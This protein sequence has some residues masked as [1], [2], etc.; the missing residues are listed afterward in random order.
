MANDVKKQNKKTGIFSPKVKKTKQREEQVSSLKYNQQAIIHNNT[1]FIIQE[2]YKTARTNIIFSVAGNHNAGCKIIG[3]TSANPGEGKTTTCINMS[4]TF[5]QTGARVLIIDGDL[6]NPSVHQYL[7]VV[8][9]DGLSTVLSMQKT[10]EDVVYHNLRPGL[11]LLTSGS[12]PPNPAELL[13]SEAMEELLKELI[14]QYD[15]I[16]IDTPPTTVVTDAAALSK[17][18]DGMVVVVREGYTTHESLDHAINLLNIA[19]AKILGFFVNDVDPSNATYGAYQ[20]RYG[21]RYGDTKYGYRY[22][23]RYG[24]RYSYRYGRGYDYHYNDKGAITY[25]EKPEMPAVNVNSST[26]A[27]AVDQA[28]NAEE[29]VGNAQ[30]YDAVESTESAQTYGAVESTESIQAYDAA[31]SAMN[32]DVTDLNS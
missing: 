20:R 27:T 32:P 17:F 1:P 30:T 12:I 5:A 18:L 10:F 23:Y 31:E 28:Y 19:D 8:K 9:T 16:F 24:R 11:D 4:I 7:G 22:S 3:F 13:S 29:N 25:G 2:A 26:S 15:Y 21:K 14:P 6:R